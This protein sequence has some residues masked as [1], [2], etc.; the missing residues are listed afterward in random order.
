MLR[1]MNHGTPS[2]QP[3]RDREREIM[4]EMMNEILNGLAE[5]A[6]R[7]WPTGDYW[8]YVTSNAGIAHG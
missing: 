4:E 1:G 3:E 6:V 7:C 2:E 8:L 5:R